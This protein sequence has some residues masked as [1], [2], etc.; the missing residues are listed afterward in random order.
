MDYKYR[1]V[2]ASLF[3]KPRKAFTTIYI[4]ELFKFQ[5]YLFVLA[6]INNVLTRK[7]L[8]IAD[9]SNNFIMKL[10]IDFAIGALFGWMPILFISWLLYLTAKWLKGKCDFVTVYNIVIYAACLPVLIS[11]L[12]TVLGITLL[13][14]N[15]NMKGIS[16]NNLDIIIIRT[17]LYLNW[18][19]NLY[20]A[21]LVVIGISVIQQF[22]IIK[23]VFNIFLAVI[24]VAIP[25]TVII[26]IPSLFH[27]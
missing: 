7:W 3:P 8:E 17:H 26:I 23:S 20:Y 11:L 4:Y 6:G 10:G 21:F 2:F 15:G 18:G 12:S 14:L 22:T 16:V 24:I 1:T 19:L 5:Y 25:L 9:V 27:H 13:R